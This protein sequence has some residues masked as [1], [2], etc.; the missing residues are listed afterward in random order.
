M[1]RLERRDLEEPQRLGPLAAA[2]GMTEK[3]FQD[4]FGYLIEPER[5]EAK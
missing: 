4:R 2:V 5:F 3:Q 1:I